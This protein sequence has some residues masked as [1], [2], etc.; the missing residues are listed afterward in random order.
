MGTEG[1]VI[2]TY[3]TQHALVEFAGNAIIMRTNA[4]LDARPRQ[5]YGRI[6]ACPEG[7][8]LQICSRSAI[9][10]IEHQDNMLPFIGRNNP[11]RI[12]LRIIEKGEIAGEGIVSKVNDESQITTK[13]KDIGIVLT[14]APKGK[15]ARC[16]GI[17]KRIDLDAIVH[18]IKDHRTIAPWIGHTQ[19]P[20]A[21]RECAIHPFCDIEPL[22]RSDCLRK[23]APP[24]E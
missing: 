8:P 14:I 22:L 6:G 9:R 12:P 20:G 17:A 21:I 18:A 4:A 11:E 13:I 3:I 7:A 16:P 10:S 23:I 19:P 24:I 15:R 1:A 5:G 2:D